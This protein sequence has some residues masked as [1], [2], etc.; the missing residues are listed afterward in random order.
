MS[1]NGDMGKKKSG[2]HGVASMRDIAR[3]VLE[4]SKQISVIA[5]HATDEPAIDGEIEVPTEPALLDGLAFLQGWANELRI[6]VTQEKRR[7]TLV[8]ASASPVSESP[9]P[10]RNNRRK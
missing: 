6:A 7:L 10:P 4:I 1:Q 2:P 9:P 8:S 5:E 3:Q